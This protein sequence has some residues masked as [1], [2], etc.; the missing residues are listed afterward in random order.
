LKIYHLKCKNIPKTA[1]LVTGLA[2]ALLVATINPMAAEAYP[3]ATPTVSAT[4]TTTTA[5][6]RED[7]TTTARQDATTTTPPGVPTGVTAIPGDGSAVVAWDAPANDG[8][9]AII[10]YKSWPAPVRCSPSRTGPP[11]PPR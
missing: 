4:Y 11:P 1:V 7:A 5:T 6:R 10:G 3:R 9:S 2:G 8:G